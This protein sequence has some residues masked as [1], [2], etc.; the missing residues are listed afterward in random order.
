[1]TEKHAFAKNENYE[2]KSQVNNSESKLTITKDYYE[3][4]MKELKDMLRQYDPS[5]VDSD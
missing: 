2:L 4:E 5:L 1:M 3:S